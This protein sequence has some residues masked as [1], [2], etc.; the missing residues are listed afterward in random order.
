VFGIA[1]AGGRRGQTDLDW[2][3]KA[4]LFSLAAL[5]A[6]ASCG[7]ALGAL[8]AL[9]PG[10]SRVTGA[11]V[12]ALS[13]AGVGLAQLRPGSRHRLWERDCETAQAWLRHGAV[14]WAIMNGAALGSGFGSRI[15]FVSWYAVPL[16]ALAFGSPALGALIYGLYGG[17]RG[18]AVWLWIARL[19]RAGPD[20]EDVLEAILEL[21]GPGKRLSAAL[22]VS[23]ATATVVAAGL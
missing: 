19:R 17:V 10:Q 9:L 21:N 14:R 12:A 22:L 13:L 2:R 16:A 6:G 7:A 5:I 3:A 11:S 23:L 4:A 15:G 20:R 18:F 8:G 1:T